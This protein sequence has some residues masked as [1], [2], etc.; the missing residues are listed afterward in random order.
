MVFLYMVGGPPELTS[1]ESSAAS[2]VDKRQGESDPQ[3]VSLRG[4]GTDVPEPI[5][6][7]RAAVTE[8]LD[9]R[10]WGAELLTGVVAQIGHRAPKAPSVVRETHPLPAWTPALSRPGFAHEQSPI[11]TPEP[12]S[13]PSICYAPFRL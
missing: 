7:L 8:D 10:R 4:A 5:E 6:L 9:E 11:P 1:K 13:P 3:T 12:T 2:N